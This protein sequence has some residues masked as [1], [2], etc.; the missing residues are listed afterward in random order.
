MGVC[1]QHDLLWDEL[2]GLEHLEFFCRFK[3]IPNEQVKEVA[4]ARLE[5][6]MCFSLPSL[7]PSCTF[8]SPT[9]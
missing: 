9:L 1:P 7:P 3:N 8:F 4:A 6:L 5:V 2:T